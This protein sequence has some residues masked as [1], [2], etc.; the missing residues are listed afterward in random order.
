VICPIQTY[1]QEEEERTLF[2]KVALHW[3]T[4]APRL[5]FLVAIILLIILFYCT[6]AR[7]VCRLWC[8]FYK[9]QCACCGNQ[10]CREICM[11]CYSDPSKC[12]VDITLFIIIDIVIMLSLLNPM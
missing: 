7:L 10:K 6:L 11:S 4:A 2:E 12:F 3:R 1:Y 5:V 9:D 8:M